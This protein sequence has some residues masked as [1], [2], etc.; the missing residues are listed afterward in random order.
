MQKVSSRALIGGAVSFVPGAYDLY[1]SFKSPQG[2]GGGSTGE[3]SYCYNSWLKH[4]ICLQS[5]GMNAIPE[6][7]CELGPGASIG[8]GIASLLCGASSYTALDV[9]D[10]YKR[11]EN[12]NILHELVSLFQ[13]KTRL[14]EDLF[15][16]SQA[17]FPIDFPEKILTPDM[18]KEH[19]A[20]ERVDAIEQALLNV[21]RSCDGIEVNYHA[22]Y[23][24]QKIVASSSFDLIMSNAVLE[25]VDDLPELYTN[26]AYWVRPEGWLSHQV[27]FRCHGITP[28]WN[29]HWAI[30]R[31][32]WWLVRGRR[33]Y[34]INRQ[35][36]SA[37]L[38]LHRKH[39]FKI[40]L[41][42]KK[43]SREGI[44]RE[45]VCDSFD[46]LADEDLSCQSAYIASHPEVG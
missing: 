45:L 41:C 21:G 8:S 29:G 36:L 5:A 20:S 13:Q 18:M 2:K 39:N 33:P 19:L 9:A 6:S 15:S 27:D 32:M 16:D 26:M 44:A 38:E 30:G 25:H 37:H 17:K 7:V 3:A 23:T 31:F 35:P 1:Q 11:D 34:L 28:E 43:T 10:F 46:F 24:S 12:V 40:R 4:L 42:N 22:P 14:K